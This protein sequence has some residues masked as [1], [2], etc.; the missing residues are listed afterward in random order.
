MLHRTRT[1]AAFAL[2]ALAAAGCDTTAPGPPAIPA[3]HPCPAW[4]L[5][6]ASSSLYEDYQ[7]S[8][9][10][11][12][13]ALALPLPPGLPVRVAQGNQQLPTHLGAD[14]W[15]WDFAVPEGTLVRAA[16]PG[17]V[18]YVRDDSTLFGADA[19]FRSE[20]NFVLVDHGGGLFTTYVHL[21]PGSAV[22]AAGDPVRAG[23][24]LA[25]TGLSGQLTGPHLHFALENAWSESLP[26]RFVDL[27]AGDCSLLPA[28]DDVVTAQAGDGAALI[29]DG[30]PSALPAETFE[31]DGVTTVA[32]LP[33]HLLVGG[34]RYRVSGTAEPGATAV[35]L[36]L[37][38]PE[39]G[40]AV[41]SWELAVA[42]G[43]FAGAVRFVATPGRYGL[44]AIA[45]RP[46]DPIRVDATVRVSVE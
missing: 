9:A 15:A 32:G 3:D 46:G 18:A 43:R 12:P 27:A 38:P 24:V 5:A 16:A 1:L 14:A 11:V 45:V 22:V 4:A 8:G 26:A 29:V 33:A 37:I 20:A 10:P 39:G 17:I 21:A 2:T 30:A 25:A 42:G 36:L 19:S 31:R 23:D 44:G 13:L 35:W 28:R 34:H 41:E 7:A 40:T 6:P